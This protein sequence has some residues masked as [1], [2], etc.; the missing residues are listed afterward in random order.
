[1]KN[2][3]II[4]II[5]LISSTCFGQE[6]NKVQEEIV[7]HYSSYTKKQKKHIFTTMANN[8]SKN[9]PQIL[10]DVSTLV[11]VQPFLER[12]GLKFIIKFSWGKNHFTKNQWESLFSKLK[13]NGKNDWCSNPAYL[14]YRK[15][16]DV[17]IVNEFFDKDY[18]FLKRTDIDFKK[19]CLD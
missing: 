16:N 1:M 4:V 15:L 11:T 10:D 13:E 3:S 17:I 2:F 9:C 6:L 5:L 7:K 12:P 14:F 19:D 8:Y 18:F